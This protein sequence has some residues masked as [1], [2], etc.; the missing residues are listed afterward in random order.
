MKNPT[1]AEVAADERGALE[2]GVMSVEERA[3]RF[4]D[5]L[6]GLL[7]K[8][9]KWDAI[10]LG[11]ARQFDADARNLNYGRLLGTLEAFQ[12]TYHM[13]ASVLRGLATQVIVL[14]RRHRA[15]QE[16]AEE[17]CS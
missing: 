14:D 13:A 15:G 7:R 8:G 3:E 4:R 10:L 2:A 1:R 6:H 12:V 16:K 9:H 5:D 11:L 17:P